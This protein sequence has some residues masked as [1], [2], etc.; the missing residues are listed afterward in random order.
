MRSKKI[1]LTVVM[2]AMLTMAG[3]GSKAEKTTAETTETVTVVE[4][5]QEES[6]QAET[7]EETKE[8][9]TAGDDKAEADI[10][11]TDMN[12]L[13]G[14]AVTSEEDDM[15]DAFES[16]SE[17]TG[18]LGDSADEI[19]N[20]FE[21]LDVS[22]EELN[23]FNID[24]YANEQVLFHFAMYNDEA[25]ETVNTGSSD[26]YLTQYINGDEEIYVLFGSD[27]AVE[28]EEAEVYC[29][30][31]TTMEYWGVGCK[32]KG[33][34]LVAPVVAGNEEAGYYFV[35]PVLESVGVDVPDTMSLVDQGISFKTNEDK[36]NK[37]SK[38]DNT[39]VTTTSELKGDE[40]IY[41]EI[42]NI[43][44]DEESLTI[45]YE[46]TNYYPMDV[47]I[48]DAVITLNGK[49]ITD[50]TVGFFE[51]EANKTIE[52]CFFIDGYEVKAGDK[53]VIKG[54]LTD[55]STFDEIGEIEFPLVLENK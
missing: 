13:L 50:S 33:I 18:Y 2:A 32:Q 16:V 44:G 37:E 29:E 15:A 41:F 48:S 28:Y 21:I 51:G 9:E 47:Y 55:Y 27:D 36:A 4:S 26:S 30:E 39:K 34:Y 7:T 31:G 54:M 40:Y 42:T 12:K 53:L 25:L 3:C 49:D 19:T 6:T 22:V 17:E 46:L 52:D 45:N 1:V 24:L 38:E 20:F 5:T 10:E 43:T 23:Q 14:K 35:L 8:T 11:F